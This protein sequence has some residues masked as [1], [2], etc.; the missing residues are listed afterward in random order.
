MP[1]LLPNQQRQGTEG[2]STSD[3]QLIQVAC[4]MLHNV[5]SG[6][7]FMHL[8][9]SRLSGNLK[10]FSSSRNL[11]VQSLLDNSKLPTECKQLIV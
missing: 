10:C 5:H 8:H 11:H 2:T 1:F 7:E 3:M 6:M 4:A 9:C